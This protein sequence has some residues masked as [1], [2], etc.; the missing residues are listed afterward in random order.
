MRR[1]LVDG[2]HSSGRHRL[3]RVVGKPLH[4]DH[5]TTDRCTNDGDLA[6]RLGKQRMGEVIGHALEFERQVSVG[7]PE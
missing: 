4:I 7:Q 6:E 2:P 5:Q 3:L 1:D